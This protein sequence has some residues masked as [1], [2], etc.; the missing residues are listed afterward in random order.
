[1]KLK[2]L[3]TNDDGFYAKGIKVLIDIMKDYGDVYVV[4]PDKSQSGQ[5]HAITMTSPLRM[6][7]VAEESGYVEYV[8]NGTPVDCVKLGCKVVL[9]EDPDL[10]VSGINHGSNAAINV[11][12]SG[13]MA[14]VF[15]GC[16]SGI[17]SIGF[18]LTNWSLDADFSA[19]E[20]YIRQVVENV[21]EHGLP[22]GLC[23]NVNIPDLPKEEIKGIRVSRQ[24]Q[25]FWDE[26]FDSRI[27]PRN[28][29]YHWMT[30]EYRSRENG[31][32]ADEW[33]LANGFVS[34]VP[35]QFD[36]TAYKH[37]QTINNWQWNETDKE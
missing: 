7:K 35:M 16:I 24:G 12:Y 25:G 13:T 34:V 22:E 36:F 26:R 17:P 31:S 2:I 14:A 23:L 33:A 11:I 9:N 3:V 20:T 27:D 4:A 29:E 19:C 30:G 8:A 10:I 1:M 18:S 6:K 28:V 37:L 5:G 15:E 32:D 21:L